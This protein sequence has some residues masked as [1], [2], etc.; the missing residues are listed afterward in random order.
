MKR[1]TNTDLIRSTVGESTSLRL[2]YARPAKKSQS[3]EP[4]F[5]KFSW[6][7][8][9]QIVQRLMPLFI[10]YLYMLIHTVQY[11]D[12]SINAI[13]WGSSPSLSSPYG[14]WALCKKT[15]LG[16]WAKNWTRA[17]LTSKPTQYKLSLF[18]LNLNERKDFTWTWGDRE[19]SWAHRWDAEGLALAQS[20]SWR[21]LRPQNTLSM[22][23]VAK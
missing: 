2:Q 19:K 16:C 20:S 14:Q 1:G 9:R 8:I 6:H 11:G 18:G 13:Y 7:C 23:N 3:A 17:C 21:H 4:A 10:V 5:F 22:S 12:N 15:S